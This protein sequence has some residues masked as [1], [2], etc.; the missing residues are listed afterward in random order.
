MGGNGGPAPRGRSGG[1]PAR[2]PPPHHRLHQP[3]A[4]KKCISAS[5]PFTYSIIIIL[6]M[7]LFSPFHGSPFPPLRF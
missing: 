6:Q 5:D 1:L 2:C 7:Q 4:W 3:R